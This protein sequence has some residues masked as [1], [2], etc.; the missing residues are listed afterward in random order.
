MRQVDVEST[1][2]RVA[3]EY[4]IRLDPE[5]LADGAKLGPIAEAA[6]M[7]PERFR[8]RYGHLAKG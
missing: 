1:S 2:Y 4:M 3:R 6:G 7:T 8:D 5:D